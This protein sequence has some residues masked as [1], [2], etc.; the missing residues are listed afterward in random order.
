[1]IKQIMVNLITLETY[2][3]NVL[4]SQMTSSTTPA[5]VS[6]NYETG[7]SDILVDRKGVDPCPYL[8]PDIRDRVCQ[9]M[10]VD[11]DDRPDLVELFD[12]VRDQ[13]MLRNENYYRAVAGAGAQYS[14]GA[15]PTGFH[16]DVVSRWRE[17][18]L[19]LEK[20]MHSV[21]YNPPRGS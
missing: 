13:V 2:G 12:Y 4:G 15:I 21:I 16:S 20:F 17:R 18:D 6:Y 19:F 7:A 11:E 14:A 8:D 9:C 3:A 1:M 10:A 5:G